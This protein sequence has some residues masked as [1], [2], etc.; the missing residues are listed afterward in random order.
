M[1]K[2]DVFSNPSFVGE[3]PR[4]ERIT[5]IGSVDSWTLRPWKEFFYQFSEAVWPEETGYVP[6]AE[7]Q[8]DA[9]I[10]EEMD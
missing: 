7:K 10:E 1:H 5:S 6:D 9:A 8:V 2:D 4:H 3:G